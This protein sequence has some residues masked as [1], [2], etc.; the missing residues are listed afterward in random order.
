VPSFT[1]SALIAY[2]Q[3][4]DALNPDD[5]ESKRRRFPPQTRGFLYFVS[6]P[7]HA[8]A[9]GEI[10]F[11]VTGSADPAAFE[12]GH[13]LVSSRTTLPWCIALRVV[14]RMVG[15]SPFFHLLRDKD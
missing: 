3:G 9:P 14:V 7:P 5:N 10:R 13:D 8:P 11:R 6:C 1:R 2:G 15:Y 12:G 4:K